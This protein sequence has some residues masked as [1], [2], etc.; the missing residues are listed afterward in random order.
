MIRLG[1]VYEIHSNKVVV[2]TPDSEFLVIKRTK[3]MYLGQQ[4]KFNIKDIKETM[5]PVYKY[6]SI[7][8]SVAA[9]FVLLFFVLGVPSY[10]GYLAINV[11]INPSIEF[12]VDQNM[13]VIDMNALNDDANAIIQELDT[14]GEDVYV[15]IDDFVDVCE[16]HGYMEEHDNIVLI[17]ATVD[18]TKIKY[19]KG[20]D[21]DKALDEFLIDVSERLNSENQNIT[22]K[23][24]KVLP[25]DREAALKDNLSMG[26]YYLIQKAKASGLDLSGDELD[27]KTIAEL[28]EAINSKGLIITADA[29]MDL[30]S[31]EPKE[32]PVIEPT[33]L[34]TIE[35]TPV[36]EPVVQTQKPVEV[37][38]KPVEV[39]QKPVVTSKPVKA[40]TSAVATMK[41]IETDRV[42]SKPVV[43]IPS[44]VVTSTIVV[45]TP[46]PTKTAK[47]TKTP[48]VLPTVIKPT[49]TKKE[50][51]E[52]E[53]KLQ[54]K[55]KNVEKSMECS[56]ITTQIQVINTSAEEIEFADIKVRYYFT[57]EEE[58]D[59]NARIYSFSKAN[60]ADVM[61]FEQF[62]Q[63]DANI[64][65]HE[66]SDN[67]MYMEVQFESGTLKEDEY[68]YIMSA[69]NL[70]DW[71]SM[72]QSNDYSYQSNSDKYSVSKKVTAYISDKLVWG[73]EP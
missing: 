7:A 22:G 72:D 70:K 43:K 40:T 33:S 56:T 2:M 6:V 73:I 1:I 61:Y 37:T 55:L 27:R 44:P 64:S 16:T 65:F 15:A 48:T 29:T 46:K 10:D 51:D 68:L 17:S 71:S 5:K 32:T 34:P 23:V 3:D 58:S 59:L 67:E 31:E 60:V 24:I 41:P 9:V 20:S 45:E 38:Q 66:L 18:D 13:K 19:V 69:F 4:V 30:E 49:P 36:P 50:S 53:G 8:S 21:E 25:E 14:K 62:N 39:T 57:R 35:P 42:T 26:K 11:D 28:L 12:V 63:N 54:I 47:V 52:N